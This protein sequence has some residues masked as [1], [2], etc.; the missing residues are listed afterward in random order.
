MLKHLLVENYALIEKLDISLEEGLTIITGE[1][2]AG[3]SI[4]LGALALILGQRADTSVL[5]HNDRKCIVEGTFNL[6]NLKIKDLF[7]KHQLDHDELTTFRREIT[8]QGKSRA[9]INDTP[10]NLNAMKELAER[11]LDIHSQH[12]NLLIGESSFQFDVVD[13]YCGNLEA[14]SAYRLAFKERQR[15]TEYLFELE[16]SEKRSRAELDYFRFQFDELDKARLNEEEFQSLESELEILRHAEEIKFN[17][18][19]AGFV[20]GG[21]DSNVISGLN[22]TIQLLRPLARY[23]EKF[24]ALL[25]RLETLHIEAKDL[26]SDFETES[27]KVVHDP[28]RAQDLQL[29]TDLLNK[30]L[31]KHNAR[32]IAELENVRDGY[33][34]KILA[35]DSLENQIVSLRHEIA[36]HD[37]HLFQMASNISAKRKNAIP[38]IEAQVTYL[39]RQL[40][41]PG[42]N[43][44][45]SRKEL[46]V[47]TLS[48][49]DQISFLFSANPG[50]EPREIAKVASGGELSRLMLSIKSMISQRNLLPTI[51]FDE[52]DA[53]IS[54]ETATKVANI[55]ESIAR[56]MQVITI[57]HLPQIASRGHCHLQVYKTLDH[58]KAL[59]GIKKIENHERILEVAKMLGG[60]KPTEVML[61][62][63]RELIFN[64]VKN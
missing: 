53:G 61:A 31:L 45:V 20:I 30:L 47:P 58:G 34:E 17:L 12:Q 29:R 11:L 48:G 64:S 3:K 28:E 24:K 26:V 2:G 59:T 55:L 60:E 13:S 8:P 32:N 5:M 16:E 25:Q 7:D 19:K 44:V 37:K 38:D 36:Q 46:A 18:G 33:K 35:I 23:N 9:F 56:N 62:T 63:A 39:L 27:E 4:V 57:T 15:K 52:I 10:V 50:S 40:G 21:A 51:I 6:Q 42:A 49:I 43:F 22:E 41:M 14:A 54:G 1:T